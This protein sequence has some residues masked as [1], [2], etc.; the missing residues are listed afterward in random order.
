MRSTRSFVEKN[1][2][3]SHAEL[4]LGDV[5]IMIGSHQR[6]SAY[7]KLI[8]HPED[9]G[10]FETQSPY[11]ILEDVD[12]HYH[13]ARK[14]GAKIALDLKEE[15]YGGKSYSCYDIDGHLWNFGSYDPWN[16]GG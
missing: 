15:D 4:T 5:M 2:I 6:E 8:K 12:T 3:V 16:A 11:I 7:A 13:R 10:G 14:R 1:G 9:I